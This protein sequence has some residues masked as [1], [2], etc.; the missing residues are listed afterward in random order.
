ME[1][2]KELK[3]GD[4]FNNY[5]HICEFLEQPFYSNSKDR[6]AQFQRW[7]KYFNFN[8]RR[9][10]SI[11]ILEVYD[12]PKVKA[13]PLVYSKDELLILKPFRAGTIYDNY[14]QICIVLDGKMQV[15]L[16]RREQQMNNWKNYFNYEVH[17]DGSIEILEIFE[18]PDDIKMI[19]C[20]KK[21]E[22][23]VAVVFWRQVQQ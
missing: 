19:H 9:N 10:H 17:E 21:K 2:I 11:E 23:S 14:K 20:K 3:Q 12:E 7:K 1:N 13:K 15:H 22:K 6:K 18:L 5:R 16:D 4:I 8:V